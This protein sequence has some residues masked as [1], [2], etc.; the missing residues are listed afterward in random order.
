MLIIKGILFASLSTPLSILTFVILSLL[1][2][3]L[4]IFESSSI[5]EILMATTLYSLYAIFLAA[6]VLTVYA[7]PV[8]LLLKSFKLNN[9]YTC[10][11]F[12]LAPAILM[13]IS[14]YPEDVY[15][16]LLFAWTSLIAG[17]IFWKK[18]NSN[19]FSV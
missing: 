8:F 16:V 13:G 14:L 3:S 9:I 18:A 12:S 6:T 17:L 1:L 15:A 5:I 19:S 11:I 7:T 2:N 4:V 10:I